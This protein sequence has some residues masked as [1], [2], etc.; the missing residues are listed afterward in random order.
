MKPFTG[1]NYIIAL[2]GIYPSQVRIRRLEEYDD[3]EEEL[4]DH[5]KTDRELRFSEAY[6][7]EIRM[8]AGNFAPSGWAYCDGQVLPIAQNSA[9]FSLLGVSL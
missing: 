6:L 7:G 1:V 9:L 5:E 8:F 2:T 3:L 4:Y